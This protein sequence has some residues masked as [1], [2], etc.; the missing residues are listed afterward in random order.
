LKRD[1]PSFTV[2]IRQNKRRARS[3]GAK[4]NWVD[5]KIAPSAFDLEPHRV[6]QAA[7]KLVEAS[8]PSTAEALPARGGRILPS[9]QEE[10]PLV[11]T[12]VVETPKEDAKP[13]LDRKRQARIPAGKAPAP[14]DRRIGAPQIKRATG[15][16]L[17]ARN[18]KTRVPE[19]N[20][21]SEA[22]QSKSLKGPEVASASPPASQPAVGERSP[23]G[24][25]KRAIFSRYV[26]RDE[27]EPGQI[28]K[29]KLLARRESRA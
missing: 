27:L 12:P 23:G 6:A 19:L 22:G 1:I 28:W 29:R 10:P 21:K 25:S 24:R 9:L 26:L 5:A 2:E 14:E 4:P 20:P 8:A 17:D 18:V 16:S 3:D 7:F 11:E 15:P 13:R